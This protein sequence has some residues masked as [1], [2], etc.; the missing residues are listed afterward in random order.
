VN[1]GRYRGKH[2]APYVKRRD[3]H[4]AHIQTHTQTYIQRKNGGRTFF[5]FAIDLLCFYILL[6]SKIGGFQSVETF[7]LT[8]LLCIAFLMSRL[9]S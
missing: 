1:I 4:S 9:N 8:S 5:A 6:E 7:L 3:L 2:L